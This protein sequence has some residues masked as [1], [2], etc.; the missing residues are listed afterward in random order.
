M[1]RIEQHTPGMFSWADL[2]TTDAAGAKQFYGNLFGWGYDDQSAGPG[3]TYTMCLCEGETAAALFPQRE[4]EKQMGLP[5]HWTCYFTVSD[6]DAKAE[7]VLKLG[8]TLI[9]A[10]FDVFS[11]G[12]MCALADPS[13]AFCALWQPKDHIGAKLVGEHGTIGWTEL[14][15]RDPPAAER[16]HRELHGFDVSSMPTP[17]GPYTIFSVGEK[18][19]AGLFPMPKEVPAEV[20]SHWVVYFNVYDIEATLA[21]ATGGGGTVT[22][23]ITP[24]PSV[25]RYA[26]LRDPQGAVFAVI[27]P[28]RPT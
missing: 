14:W 24:V 6:V 13:G 26:T 16:F 9:A 1:P 8:G 21:K 10:P 15:T 22:S 23:P 18:P 20:P 25:G 11:A 12:R 2:S 3:M 7:Q 27:E 5:A 4:A 19:A 17:L 28:T